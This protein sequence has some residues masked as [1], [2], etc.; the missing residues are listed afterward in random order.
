MWIKLIVAVI[1]L[2]IAGCFADSPPDESDIRAAVAGQLQ[3]IEAMTNQGHAP[4][5][6]TALYLEYFSADPIVL[7]YGGETLDGTDEIADFYSRVFSIGTLIN[8][9]YAEPMI[10]ISEGYVV[11]IYQGTAEI[12]PPDT[13]ETV[14]Y[15]NVYTD[16]LV[17]Q[18]GDWK[19][20][21]HSWVPAPANEGTPES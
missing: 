12:Q 18:D 7:P 16:V 10:G 21:W 20:Q 13:E 3:D 15:T 9:A 5:E 19:I 4:E 11:R 6:M 1:L 17:Y 14:S 8:N 2:S